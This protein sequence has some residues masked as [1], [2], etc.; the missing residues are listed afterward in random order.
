MKGS[1]RRAEQVYNSLV[2]YYGVCITY[3]AG[4]VRRTP[5]L[6]LQSFFGPYLPSGKLLICL[7]TYHHLRAL[8]LL[9]ISLHCYLRACI[10]NHLLPTYRSRKTINKKTLSK[11]GSTA[12]FELGWLRSTQG[13][14]AL[15]HNFP[16]PIASSSPLIPSILLFVFLL[17]C[18][19]SL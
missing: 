15:R 9:S 3:Y 13:E 14:V 8:S 2:F 12:D 6:A 18:L 4:S 1:K 19:I 16:F 7:L 5:V 10:S 17:N 11:G